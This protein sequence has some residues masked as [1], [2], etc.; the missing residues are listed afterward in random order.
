M[1]IDFADISYLAEGNERQRSAANVLRRND[2]MEQ[3]QAF[4]P[5]LTGTVPIHLDTADSDLDIICYCPDRRLF[6]D[7]LQRAFSKAER[8]RLQAGSA[9][10]DPVVANFVL[11]GWPIEVFGANMP[12]RDQPAYRHMLIEYRLL[13]KRGEAFRTQV[14]ALKKA[15]VKTE[16]AF[17]QVL[18]LAG[19]PYLVL[20]AYGE[21]AT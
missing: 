5:L 11:D 4:D 2:V 21:S 6:V 19:D 18:K 10:G 1:A 13:E 20:L 17:A 12:T 8:F 14:M 7:V 15:G 16:P 9:D 3:L